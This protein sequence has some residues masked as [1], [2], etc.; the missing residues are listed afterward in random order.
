MN[1]NSLSNSIAFTIIVGL[2]SLAN[3]GM[4]GNLGLDVRG[5]DLTI[6]ENVFF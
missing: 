5:G 3:M 2:D 4:K 6:M 1:H